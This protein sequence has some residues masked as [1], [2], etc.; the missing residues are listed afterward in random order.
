MSKNRCE[1]GDMFR[2]TR[3]LLVSMDH[4][5]RSLV[6]ARSNFRSKGSDAKDAGDKTN[7]SHCEH[8]PST[9]TKTQEL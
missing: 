9:D 7:L 1:L 8:S 3:D 6:K 5:I 2:H 4:D